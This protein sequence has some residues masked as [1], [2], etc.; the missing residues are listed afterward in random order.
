MRIVLATESY[1]PYVSGV[2]ISVDA[3]ARG[4]GLLGHEVLVLAPRPAHGSRVVAV[5]SPGPEPRYAWLSS[6][7]LPVVVPGGYRMPWPNPAAHA[8]E[9]ARTFGPDL[10]HAHSPFVTGVLAR[11]LA[12][13]ASVP[14]VFTH[15]TR[16]GDYGHYLGP[17]AAPGVRLTDAY[18]RRFWL[19][20][21][22]IIAPSGDLAG[23]IRDRLPELARSRVHVIP[24]GIDVEAIRAI[25]PARGA[26]WPADAVVVATLG[27]LAPEKSPAELIDAFALAGERMARLRFVVIGGGPSEAAL[28]RRA[29]DLGD[30]IAFTGALPRPEALARLAA[31]D[32]FAFASRTETQGLVLAEA[33]ATGLPAVAVAGPGVGDSVRDGVDGIVV[34]AGEGRVE[35]LAGALVELAADDELRGRMAA[36]A[37]GDADRFAVGRRT[38]EVEALYRRL[39]TGRDV[40]T[41]CHAIGSAYNADHASESGGPPRLPPN[42]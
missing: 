33:L 15:H 35:R 41:A 3:L 2:T 34:D 21:A 23:E 13:A 31:A 8:L 9:L 20:C 1:L 39:V 42:H 25:E 17:L 30:R 7:E 16:F 10:V 22:A 19:A 14:L 24:T 36:R 38:A 29:A 26:G 32:L 27:R 40:G 12:R 11:R 37:G 6:Y 5:G 4:L 28:R 18:L